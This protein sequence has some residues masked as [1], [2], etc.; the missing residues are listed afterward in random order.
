MEVPIGSCWTTPPITEMEVPVLLPTTS[1]SGRSG[2]RAS[3]KR[4]WSTIRRR[5]VSPMAIAVRSGVTVTDWARAEAGAAGTP[6]L[7][8]SGLEIGTTCGGVGRRNLKAAHPQG[9]VETW[10]S[11]T[12]LPVLFRH[13]LAGRELPGR[14]AGLQ[15]F[16]VVVHRV[17]LL[18]HRLRALW[19]RALDV[20]NKLDSS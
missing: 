1:K 18:A 9:V 5:R 2:P 3:S 13:V 6:G 12:S 19:L 16:V 8:M 11:S 10:G 20:M 4:P 17:Q 7:R 15:I 14:V